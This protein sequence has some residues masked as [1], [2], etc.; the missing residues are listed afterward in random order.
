MRWVIIPTGIRS[1]MRSNVLT[2]DEL[3]WLAEKS[4]LETTKTHRRYF[5][6]VSSIEMPHKLAVEFCL[7]FDV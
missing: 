1:V 7:R 5:P 2:K 4:E 6:I 3:S